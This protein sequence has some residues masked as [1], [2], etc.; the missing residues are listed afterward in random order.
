[1]LKRFLR[2]TC[3]VVL[4]WDLVLVGTIYVIDSYPEWN[5]AVTNFSHSSWHNFLNLVGSTT[6]GFVS[7]FVVSLISILATVLIIGQMQG[8]AV[9]K[10]HWV[11]TACI[12]L[13]VLV[14]TMI[15]VYGPLFV[16]TVARTAYEDHLLLVTATRT[17]MQKNADLQ[18]ASSHL[19][20]PNSRQDEIM[21]LI[22]QINEYK[23]AQSPAIRV[24]P[25]AHESR[26]PNME[27][28]LTT[29]VIR[30]PV[31]LNVECDFNIA[32]A[33]VG[34]LTTAG[35]SA[36]MVSPNRLAQ[37]KFKLLMQSPA[38]SPATPLWLTVVL[39]PPVDRMPRC[40]VTS[41]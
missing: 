28:L 36:F 23:K 2:V 16:W 27:Y 37:N 20:D 5:H 31:D 18:E 35:S 39:V 1:M 22:S 40:S 11:E 25:I 30:E 10:Q 34:P 17:L 15:A 14:G 33:D 24:Y 13:L 41:N 29:G 7:P 9:M 8:R 3:F 4:L 38:W 32:S 19:V 6:A 26:I 12:S 21:K